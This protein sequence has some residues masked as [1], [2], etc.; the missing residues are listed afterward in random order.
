[1]PRPVRLLLAF[2]RLESF[3]GILLL[4]CAAAA[5][6]W[7]NSPWGQAY[8]DFWRIEL[9][10]SVGGF[11]LSKP[12]L[13]W[14][15]E[16]LMALFFFVV[17]LE[18]KREILVGALSS[19]KR[20]LL[21]IAAALGGMLVPALLYLALNA[22]TPGERGWGVPMATDIAFA[23]GVLTLL[24]RRIPDALKAFLLALAIVDDIG[25]VLVIA[26]FY[27]GQL[28]WVYLALGAGFLLILAGINRAGARHPLAYALLGVGLWLMF[29]KSGVHTTVAGVLVAMTVPART[30]ID[31]AEFLWR[32]RSLLEEFERMKSSVGAHAQTISDSRQQATVQALEAACEGVE[33]PL[34]RLERGL[35]PWVAFA[36]MPLFA[37]AN[38]GV[39]LNG[40]AV[41][42]LI[43]PVS[44]G[45]L[46]GLVVGKQLGVT[47]FAWL[48]VRARLAELPRGVGWRE[49]YGVGWLAG[50]G[51]T[52][53]LFIAHLAFD[54]ASLLAVAKV[55]VLAASLISGIG[56]WL[57][58]RDSRAPAQM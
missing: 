1:M 9:A 44:L 2:I 45:V 31:S 38:A 19:P 30:R 35:H 3:S 40:E 36:I 13:L 11:G 23:V 10:V 28:S 26:L 53:S 12:L 33:T 15:N 14:I 5:L 39:A 58:L 54:G 29:L 22:G 8:F 21:P 37:L 6:A 42:D 55:G 50:I 41:T 46:T 52:M 24:G 47:F 25:A 32:S 18:I 49:I 34:Q 27:T 43:H 20:A 51:F 56:G 17:G 7:A 16:G 57:I 48:A 4:L